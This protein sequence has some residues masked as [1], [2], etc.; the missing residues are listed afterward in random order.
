MPQVHP[1]EEPEQVIE[2]TG[3]ELRSELE[4]HPYIEGS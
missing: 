2:Y 1:G 4:A 3:L